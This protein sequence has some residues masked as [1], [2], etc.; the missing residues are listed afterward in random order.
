MRCMKW[1]VS[2]GETCDLHGHFNQIKK[3]HCF[4][5]KGQENRKKLEYAKALVVGKEKIEIA[6]I[7]I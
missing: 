7:P 3:L 4:S 1:V 2:T 6:S 5:F